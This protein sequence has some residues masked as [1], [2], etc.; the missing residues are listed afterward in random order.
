MRFIITTRELE[1][2]ERVYIVDAEH[3]Q[4]ALSAVHRN[5]T[6]P[7]ISS[8]VRR[9][10]FDPTIEPLASHPSM[11]MLRESLAIAGE[12]IDL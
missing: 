10:I 6:R 1:F 5:D 11:V 2:H 7:L 4:E 3:E 8:M 12:R 9:R